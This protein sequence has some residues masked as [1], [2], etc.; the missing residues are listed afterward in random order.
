MKF[1]EAL[2]ELEQGQYVKRAGW[3]KEEGYL[4]LMPGIDYTW[5]ILTTPKAN[6]GLHALSVEEL[7]ATDWEIVDY[8]SY[9]DGKAQ[10]DDQ[11]QE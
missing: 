2:K 8:F 7:N 9:T 5:K 3:T 6:A 1:E 11:T 10:D 4:V